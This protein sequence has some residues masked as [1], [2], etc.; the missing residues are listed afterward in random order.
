MRVRTDRSRG[1]R[2]MIE[3]SEPLPESTTGYRTIHNVKSEGRYI[4]YVEVNYLQKKDVKA[5]RRTKRKLRIG[6]PFGVRVFIDRKKG[7]VTA[8]MLGRERLLELAATLKAKFKRLE[9]RDIYFL[10]LDGE[11]R[12]IIGRTTEV[13]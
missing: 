6:Q 13:Q 2:E 10:E 3:I 4:G 9:E 11:K 7:G 8:S 5:F 1:G 12:I